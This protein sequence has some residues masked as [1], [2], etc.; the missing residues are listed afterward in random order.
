MRGR[1]L[2]GVS[3]A[4]GDGYMPIGRPIPCSAVAP[5]TCF[6]LSHAMSDPAQGFCE[7]TGYAPEEI[8][9]RNCRILQ[10]RIVRARLHLRFYGVLGSTGCGCCDAGRPSRFLPPP[11]SSSALHPPLYR[12]LHSLPTP[13]GPATDPRAAA[14]LAAAIAAAEDVHV[15]L[16]NYRR[17]GTPFWNELFVAPLRSPAGAVVHFVGVLS[18]VPDALAASLL[19]TQEALLVAGGF[20]AAAVGAGKGDR[21][22][23]GNGGAAPMAPAGAGGGGGRAA[24]AAAR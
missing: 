13:Q 22:I 8:L 21:G 11:A 10:V 23:G 18:V 3:A 19:S 4:V 5:L 16:R 1:Q 14:R 20:V 9:G 15:V 17:D 12:R 24:A 2:E 6:S 7:L